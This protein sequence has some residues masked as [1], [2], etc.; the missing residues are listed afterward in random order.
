MPRFH[1]KP[2]RKS[3]LRR[4][5]VRIGGE[6]VEERSIALSTE[7]KKD[8]AKHREKADIVGR[9]VGVASAFWLVEEESVYGA[10][11]SEPFAAT[12]E[13]IVGGVVTSDNPDDESLL[14][15][16]DWVELARV[17][18]ESGKGVI[19]HVR[20]RTSRLFRQSPAER[21]VHVIAANVERAFF[22]HAV[23]QPYFSRRLLDR[24]LIAAE[25]GEVEPVIVFNKVDLGIPPDVEHAIAF[26]RDRLGI[27]TCLTSTV[28]GEGIE[29]VRSAMEGVT[30]VLVGASGVGK[31]ALVN[32]CFGMNLQ[33]VRTISRKYQRGRHTT[34]NARL[35]H[36][37]GGG[38][39]ID[40]PGLREFAL[41]RIAPEELAFYFHDFDPYYP[42]CKYLPC[43]H[44][45]EPDCA[46]RAAV[47]RGDIESE[48][49]ESYV[50]IFES[51]NEQEER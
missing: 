32:A 35:F 6:E 19:V 49:Y 30:S 17:P 8:P 26:Y 5:A 36:L 14:A 39:L 28:T 13:C 10:P 51:L 46:V 41:A 15:V 50:L 9:I 47:D 43:T 25:V 40:T 20:Q 12:H 16:G 45:H 18:D 22:V 44:T 38:Q 11:H 34:T 3:I 1:R 24:H 31:S 33:T 29:Q 7:L 37:P 4:D 23:T 42:D 27:R 48:R 21:Q 2:H